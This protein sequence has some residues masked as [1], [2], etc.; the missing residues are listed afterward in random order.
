MHPCKRRRAASQEA[1]SHATENSDEVTMQKLRAAAQR[2]VVRYVQGSSVLEREK[3][4]IH[5]RG[6]EGRG[7]AANV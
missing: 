4:G 1:P 7:R 2:S 5:T 3:G 6:R